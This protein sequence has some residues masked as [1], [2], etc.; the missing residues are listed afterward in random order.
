M[1]EKQSPKLLDEISLQAIKKY[2]DDGDAASGK[3]DDVK[4]NNTSVV[5]SKIA[6]LAV[7][8]TYNS[9]SNKIASQY[10]DIELQKEVEKIS[11]KLK[12]HT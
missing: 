3:V 10:R 6:N 5:S 7:D 9:S 4:V 12:S 11:N 1:A 8:G 2:I